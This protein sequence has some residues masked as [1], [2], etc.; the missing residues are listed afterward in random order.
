MLCPEGLGKQIL[1]KIVQRFQVQALKICLIRFTAVS[2]TFVTEEQSCDVLSLFF[3][4]VRNQT[5]LAVGIRIHHH[6]QE[7]EGD[8]RGIKTLPFRTV[9]CVQ[10]MPSHVPIARLCSTNQMCHAIYRKFV[11]DVLPWVSFESSLFNVARSQ[12]S[13]QL[14]KTWK[15]MKPYGFMNDGQKHDIDEL[16]MLL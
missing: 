2:T 8:L 4:R 16:L 9:N 5:L 3:C 6:L 12:R 13:I 10:E 14:L 1:Q 11:F 15:H 7:A